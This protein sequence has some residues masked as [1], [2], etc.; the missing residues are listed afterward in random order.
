[1]NRFLVEEDETTRLLALRWRVASVLK[2]DEMKR[3]RDAG[4]F[5]KE[6]GRSQLALQ[7][8]LSQLEDIVRDSAGKSEVALRLVVPETTA[9]DAAVDAAA[10]YS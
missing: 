1:M 3:A 7:S 9:R 4:T 2:P 5:F 6:D 10:C 8:Q